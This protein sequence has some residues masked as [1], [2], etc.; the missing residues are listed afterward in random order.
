MESPAGRIL[1]VDDDAALLKV[2]ATYLGRLGYAVDACR[3]AAEAWE[4]A[5]VG[6]GTYGW[7]LVDLNMPGMPGEEL[8]RRIL[9][10]NAATR[11]LV[12]SGYPG[13]DDRLQALD[14]SRVKFL[15]KPFK[16]QE[17]AAALG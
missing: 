12:V 3:S 13:G 8:A 7:A 14:A 17:L 6:G 15:H 16:P 10:A 4:K 9:E 2:M 1:M 5:Q 11:V